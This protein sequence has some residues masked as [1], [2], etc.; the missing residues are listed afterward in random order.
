[1]VDEKNVKTPNEESNIDQIN[2]VFNNSSNDDGVSESSEPIVEIE[3]EHMPVAS[4]NISKETKK[5]NS[6]PIKV[7][8][9]PE[10]KEKNKTVIPAIIPAVKPITKEVKVHNTSAKNVEKKSELKAKPVENLKSKSV[11]TFKKNKPTVI[12]KIAKPLPEAKMKKEKNTK[13]NKKHHK[14]SKSNKSMLLWIGIGILALLIIIAAIIYVPKLFSSKQSPKTETTNTVAATVNGETIYLQTVLAEYNKLNPV[15][16]SAY[17]VESILNKSIDELLLLQEAKAQDIVIKSADI[18]KEIDAIKIQNQLSD[19]QLELALEQQNMTLKDLEL[20]IEKSLQIRILLNDTILKDINIT[21]EQ[22]TAY[23]NTNIANYAVPQKVTVQHILIAVTPNVT[24]S[25][26]KA[27]IDQ[28]N[29]ELTATNFCDLVTKYSADAGSIATC[30]TYTFAKGDFNNPEFENP[31]FDLN[32]GETT[33]V[34]TIFGYHLIKKLESLPKTTKALSEVSTDIQTTLHDEIAQNR[35]ELFMKELQ[36]KA[37]I[38]NYLTKLDNANATVI[39]VVSNLDEFAKCLTVK[40]AKFYGAYWC[41]H[42][43]NQKTLFGDSLKYVQYIECAVEGQ[44]QVQT[45]EC[46]TAGISGYPTW[47]INGKTYPGEQSLDSLAKLTGCV[48]P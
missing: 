22:I 36:Q 25:Q 10:H 21:N 18:Q 35:F 19:S 32:V 43:N 30:G 9:K 34:K 27:Q 11:K 40:D 48:A 16:K 12:A 42:C 7:A 39:P 15:L 23:Y 28:I 44:P 14:K 1:M 29:T 31:S 37:V 6:K 8:K 33:I 17:S 45:K 38:V 3:E 5:D 41:A 26:A 4:K 2:S 46:T 24:E 20:S 13:Q 47:I